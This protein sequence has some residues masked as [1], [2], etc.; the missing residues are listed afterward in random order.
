M[1]VVGG[2]PAGLEA[3]R[4]AAAAG[5]RVR[6]AER[7][8][9][10]GG[11]LRAAAVGTSRLRMARLADWLEAECRRLGVT[12]ETG[13]TVTAA[14]LDAARA[15]GTEVILATGSR[16]GAAVGPRAP[17]S[18]RS[19]R[20][21]G[22]S[23]PDGPVVVHDPVGGP[24]GVAVAEWLAAAGR[25]VAIV[26]PDQ[27]IG[28]LLS[29][30][31]D[32]ADANVRLQRAGVTREPRSLL[33]AAGG[34]TALLEDVWTGEQRRTGC[35]VLIDCGHRLPAEELYQL[36]PGTVRAGDCVAPRSV[37][38]A[39]LEGRR[40]AQALGADRPPSW[41]GHRP[42]GASRPDSAPPRNR[43][44]PARRRPAARGHA[45][46]CGPGDRRVRSDCSGR[47]EEKGPATWQES[48]KARSPSS[49]A[50]RAARAARNVRPGPQEGRGSMTGRVAGKVA[51]ITGA[52]RGQG[53]SH[54]I[55]LAEEGADII[56]VDICARSAPCRYPM[57]TPEDLAETVKAVE[58]LDRRIVASQADV[59]DRAAL[60][61]ALDD[62]R[63]RARPAGHRLRQRRHLHGADLGR[64]DAGGLAGH[65]RHQPDRRAGTRGGRARR[66]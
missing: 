5:H 9:R 36:R 34:G 62:G 44:G 17:R 2:G 52:A 10:L 20:C 25:A 19:P 49:P 65:A 30:T 43:P 11:T 29:L 66:T 50:Q 6:L 15:G 4:V 53:R 37:Y 55:R 54:A 32:L 45:H 59:R 42:A 46:G 51:F 23:L 47:E 60:K 35:A 64:G 28:R 7:G 31:G 21:R 27:V 39:V 40:A 24:V 33:R 3:A 1:L 58:A 48:S 57:A 26:S 18:T 61:A 8:A 16:A 12:L 56:A 14:D 13:T 22:G 63:G 41:P 38:E